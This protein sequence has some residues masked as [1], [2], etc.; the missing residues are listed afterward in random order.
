[1]PMGRRKAELILADDERQALK[2]WASRPKSTQQLA[3]RSRIVLACA[4]GLDNKQVA[5]K[6]G[7]TAQTVDKWRRRFLERRLDGLA[8]QERPGAPRKVS[9]EEI[10]AVITRTLETKPKTAT[11]WSTRGMAEA[12]GLSQST[13]SRV[14]RAFGLK[15][16][17]SDTFKL[18]N[19]PYVVEKV[20][21]VVGLY[22]APPRPRPRALRRREE[23]DP[24]PGPHAAIA[25][26]AARADRAADA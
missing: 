11:H 25:A 13:I 12:T 17:R 1:M 9:D 2:T 5:A 19:D 18:S 4:D 7:V 20:R 14:W 16:H 23:P 15:P 21:D 10:E 3:T 22:M 26:D 24:G 6:L 8:D